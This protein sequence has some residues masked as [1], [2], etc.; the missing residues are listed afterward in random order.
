[1]RTCVRALVF[2]CWSFVMDSRVEYHDIVL[3]RR[4]IFVILKRTVIRVSDTVLFVSL[5]GYG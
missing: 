2:E 1:M 4:T 5:E 3:I